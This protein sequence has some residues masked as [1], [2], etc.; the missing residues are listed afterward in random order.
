MARDVAS[1]S[2][3]K[4]SSR[5]CASR[6]AAEPVMAG[7]TTRPGRRSAKSSSN[8]RKVARTAAP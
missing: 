7:R 4:G 2:C 5:A 8:V 6:R 3:T 1:T